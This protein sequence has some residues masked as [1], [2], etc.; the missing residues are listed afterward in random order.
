MM[1]KLR[2]A[3]VY[4]FTQWKYSPV[5]L[6][7]CA[8]CMAVTVS[9]L[10]VALPW[11]IIALGGKKIAVGAS[12]GLLMG[13]YIVSCVLIR[14]HLGRLGVKR[15]VIVSTFLTGVVCALLAV[16][17]S[18]T[19]ILVLVSLQAVVA[20]AFWS[21]LVGWL[22][23]AHEGKN[24]NHRLGRFNFSWSVGNILGLSLGGPLLNIHY[25]LP[26]LVD[27]ILCLF[28]CVLAAVVH[29]ERRV[30]N[31]EDSIQEP[32]TPELI[33][34]RW[35][36]RIGL[37]V[38]SIALGL[39]RAPL[40]SLFEELTSTVR[41]GADINSLVLGLSG[42]MQMISFILMGRT[43]RWHYHL[44]WLLG[45][46]LL[47]V[48]LLVCVGWTGSVWIVGFC[49][50][51]VMIATSF[52]YSSH[53]FYTLSGGIERSAGMAVH[54]IMLA[55][56]MTIGAFGGGCIGQWLNLQWAYRM[57]AAVWLIGMIVQLAIYV[58]K[59]PVNQLTN[60]PVNR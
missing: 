9:I 13:V 35:I 19:L 42:G 29:Q 58:R 55:T 39:M 33:S 59:K 36:S 27:C 46:Q 26:F 54:E 49:A 22:S 2:G 40:A 38:G 7:A 50:V 60:S 53:V 34:F 24:L 4:L 21:P 32:Y 8:F 14:P 47:G 12:G 16:A 37:V 28:L 31:N 48:L 45:V 5:A 52:L 44:G 51:T 6:Y 18:V 56:G 3:A 20:G 41:Q 1:A 30:T 17:S 10:T 43:E 15:L 11:R 25:Q 57:G 23:G